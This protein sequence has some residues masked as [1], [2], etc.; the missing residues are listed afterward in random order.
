[1]K[2]TRISMLSGIERTRD[3]PCTEDQYSLYEK[4]AHIQTAMP[5]I[6]AGDREFIISGITD[7]EWD[8][9]FT[10]EDEE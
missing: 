1:M 9:V 2:I 3:I 6:S 7:E 4:G 8:E 5:N 10:E